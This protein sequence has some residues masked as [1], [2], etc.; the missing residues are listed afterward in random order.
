MKAIIIDDEKH[1]REGLMLLAEWDSYGID[2][3]IEA[4]DGE[5]AVSLITEHQPE[6]IFTDMRMPKRDGISV[7]KWIHSSN[8]NCKTIV[9]SGYDDFQYMRNA[10]AF[11]SFDYILKPIQPHVLHDTL[12]RAVKE[13]NEQRNHQLTNMENRRVI[14]EVKPLYLDYLLT[15]EMDKAKLSNRA[16]EQIKK[17]FGLDVSYQPYTMAILPMNMMIQMKYQ[18]DIDLAFFSVLNISNEILRDQKNGIAFK[19]LNKEEEIVILF[20]KEQGIQAI[21]EQIATAIY[22]V[23]RV[24]CLLVIGQ[25]S[26]HISEA[27]LSAHHIVKKQ[28]LLEC[29]WNTTV[30]TSDNVNHT[31]VIHLFDY[32]E[33]IKWAIQSGSTEQIDDILERIY[34]KMEKN[35]YISLEQV[36]VWE[37]QFA[38][39]KE[40]W[41][42][43]YEIE[44]K[45]ELYKGISYWT[46]DGVFS[47][48]KFKAEKRKEFHDLLKIVYHGQYKKEKN[49]VQMIEEY[50]RSNYQKDIKLKEIADR[51]FLSREYIS[52]KF[53]QEYEATITDYVTKIRIDK[54]KELL[55]NPFLKIYEIA[56]T[57]GYQND[58]YFIKVFKKN[59]GMTP[60][61]YRGKFTK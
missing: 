11:G 27:Y 39:L 8:L 55:E 34:N 21:A 38:I 52:R 43:E 56:D 31:E 45:K 37:N 3:I 23:T 12:Q 51:F 7:L 30:L 47:M 6:I 1:V 36:D 14:N 19:N 50:I 57:V 41:L 40:H 53:K 44:N 32:T 61:E 20:W 54:A 29:T 58:K 49:S 24:H 2:T 59:V 42:K 10:I 15:N 25:G 26:L 48:V 33:E 60:N 4:S 16:I 18:G 28:N 5:E 46:G 13:W 35:Q 22:Q 17:E 9:V